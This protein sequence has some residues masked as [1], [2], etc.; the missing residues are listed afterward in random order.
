MADTVVL[1]RHPAPPSILPVWRSGRREEL[2]HH[3][4][5][6][7]LKL[8]VYISRTRFDAQPVISEL[9][10]R[11]VMLMLVDIDAAYRKVMMPDVADSEK[12]Y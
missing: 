2:T 4:I 11:R 8:D 1:S 10:D 9:P 6:G 5:A 12:E 7:W 3:G